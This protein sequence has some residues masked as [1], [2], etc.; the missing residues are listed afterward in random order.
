MHIACIYCCVYV[1]MRKYQPAWNQLKNNPSQ[2]L[3][4]S[5]HRNYHP[6]IYK[7][8]IKEKWMDTVYHVELDF[9]GYKAKL[10]SKSSGDLLTVTLTL[11]PTLEA[12]FD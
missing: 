4:I 8:I 7:A 10:T 5:A 3:V 11:H 12:L 2:P 1:R 9:K 6:R